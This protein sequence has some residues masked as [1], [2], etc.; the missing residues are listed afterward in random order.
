MNLKELLLVIKETPETVTFDEV[1][2]VIDTEYVFTPTQFRN[3]LLVNQAGEN[4]GS[5]KIF[6]FAKMH[7]LTNRQTLHCFGDYYRDDVLQ[8]PGEENHQN[9]RN[10]MTS[11][12]KE[13]EFSGDA[14]NKA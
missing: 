13:I 12:W 1:I 11:G 7:E 5:C 10:F 2:Q 6:S 9:I 8:N 4:S 3:G 14:L